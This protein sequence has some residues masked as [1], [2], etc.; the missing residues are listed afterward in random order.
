MA[1][2]TNY[3]DVNKPAKVLSCTTN[4]IS[5]NA[6]WPHNDGLGDKWWSSGTN[7]KYYRWNVTV[8]VTAQSHGSHLTRKDF[9]YNGLDVQVGDWIAE[10]TSGICCRII[11]ISAKSTTSVT[12]VVE[13]W[14][15]YNTFRSTS[16]NGIFATGQAV[17]FQLNE[18]GHP[19]ID[20]VPASI[21]SSTFYQN[22]NSRF[23][24]LNPQ[25]HYV[26]DQ[27]AHGFSVGDVIS[28]TASGFAKTTSAS[29]NKTIGTVTN[30]GPG[31]NQFMMRPN[32]RIIDFNPA[33]PGS[34]GDFIYT[35]NST[36]G[37]LTTTSTS[38]KV[39]FLKIADAISSSI[40]GTQV[41]PTTTASDVLEINETAVTFTGG[42]L[43]QTISDI[44]GGT[45]THGV[46]AS[47]SPSPSTATTATESL[48]YGLVGIY[49]GGSI[50]INGTAVN[51]ST[52]TAGQATY[53][54]AVGIGADIVADVNA[55]GPTNIT[56]SLSG[57]NVVLTNSSG[58]AITIVNTGNDGQGNP[59]AGASSGSGWPLSTGASSGAFIK[60]TRTDGGEILL[61]ETTGTPLND[62]GI[63]SVH[64]GRPP[65]AVTVEQGIISGGGT[66]VV[67]DIS[68]RDALSATVGDMVFVID[69]GNG[70]YG[71]FVYSGGAW[72]LLADEDS[73]NTDA[74]TLSATVTQAGGS[75]TT[76]V[77][78]VSNTSRITLVS[79]E[80]T[81][82]FDHAS[83]TLTVGDSGDPDRLVT[84]NDIDLTSTGT[85]AVQP[86]YQ[87]TTGADVTINAYLNIGSAT[88]GT[89]KILVS[90]M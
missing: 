6:Q 13:D 66:T 56:A 75:G 50:T 11:S 29:A 43:T 79:I 39:Q 81:Q 58:G 4:S 67:N 31:P 86:A 59:V 18:N 71:F 27:T 90:Y 8:T 2:K 44:N 60:L 46:T 26:L 57:T 15:R 88:T 20:P 3:I 21:T 77:G 80:V 12:M 69:T 34:V 5:N 14:L 61:D 78:T 63:H 68:A 83:A 1:Y 84:D 16:G 82:A 41:D 23:Q 37:G 25:M 22:I 24:Y 49:P 19:M 70:E 55:A 62:L 32:T 47:S 73:A 17:I 40:T 33:I 52:T 85:Y 38:G 28:I 87:Y 89:A 65:L 36:P 30:P 74:N 48:A 53:G 42:N 72:K 51:F 54:I 35:D 10:A 64:N 45:S 76:A 9:E 7:P